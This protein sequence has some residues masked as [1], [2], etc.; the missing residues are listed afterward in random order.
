MNYWSTLISVK[1]LLAQSSD[2]W[3]ICDVRYDLHDPSA[4]RAAWRKSAI[5]RADFLDVNTQ[6][7][8]HS[9]M[10]AG[11]HPLPSVEKMKVLFS[12]LAI[13]P[14]R[15]V[16]AYDNSHG[17]FAA[18][19]WW[20]LRF[21][22]HKRV[23]VLDGGWQAWLAAG[24]ETHRGKNP[25]HRHHPCEFQADPQ[26]DQLVLAEHVLEQT[27]LVD[28]RDPA[29]YSGEV[30]PIDP[31]AGHI[32]G[33]VNHYWK[34][35]LDPETGLFLSKGKLQWLM[36]RLF[37]DVPSSDVAWYCGSGVTACH[38]LLA[39]DH[40]EMGMGKLYAGSWSEWCALQHQ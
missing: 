11:R 40:A 24:G 28:S 18:R 5:P 12:S 7:S 21:L 1:N 4:G 31:I 34:D 3:L 38:N 25:A 36:T 23:A 13:H 16:V 20:M 15:Q 35:N 26:L 8:D 10:G 39:Q 14:E 32:E 2:D 30:E 27:L 19:L 17:S 37:D 6:L 29:R 33:A 9:R 22:G